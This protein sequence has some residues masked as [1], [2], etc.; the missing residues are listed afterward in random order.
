MKR[1]IDVIL[2]DGVSVGTPRYDRQ[3]RRENAAVESW[4]D[5]CPEDVY[6]KLPQVKI[7]QHRR[8][9]AWLS[10]HYGRSFSHA[11]TCERLGTFGR[12]IRGLKTGVGG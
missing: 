4:R 9:A 11:F 2:G 8:V 5:L 7:F 3:G 6:S 10:C 12:D 1:T